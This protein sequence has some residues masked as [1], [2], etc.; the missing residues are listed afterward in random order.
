MTELLELA[1][2]GRVTAD[3]V[4]GMA[5]QVWSRIERGERFLVL[6]DRSAMTAPTAEGRAAVE[7]LFAQWDRI[8][9]HVVGWAD[10]FDERRAQSLAGAQVDDEDDEHG[11]DLPYPHQLFGDADD[12]RRW[13]RGLV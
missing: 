12:A 2:T 1:V 5:A 13:L 4:R 6:F 3:A 11:D 7:A 10:V 8:A 9:P